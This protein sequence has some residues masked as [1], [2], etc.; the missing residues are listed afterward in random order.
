MSTI[1]KP[2]TFSAGQTIIASQ[3]NANFDTLY[4]DYNG[5]ITNDN[6]SNSANINGSKLLSTSTTQLARIGLGEAADT[7]ATLVSTGQYFARNYASSTS[8]SWNNSNVQ[9][10]S[11]TTGTHVLVFSNPK[12]GGR[13]LLMIDQ[14][15]SVSSAVATF[16]ATV[17]FPAGVTSSLSTTTG[18]TDICTFVYS[19]ITTKYYG[20]ISLGY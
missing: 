4:D 15:A 12:D 6:I 7:S 16:P 1:V 9:S 19:G 13:Y 11:L 2:N 10:V 18:K 3:H 20:G 8:V 14:P 17:L 5:G